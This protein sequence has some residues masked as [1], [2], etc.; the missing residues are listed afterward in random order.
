MITDTC[1]FCQFI[2]RNITV[3][4]CSIK[5][6][7]YHKLTSDY[8]LIDIYPLDNSLEKVYTYINILCSKENTM[9]EFCLDC[10]NKMNTCDDSKTKY[11]LSGHLDLCEGCGKQKHIIIMERKTYYTLKLK[12]LILP[13][14]IAYIIIR[15][16]WRLLI[17]PYLIFMYIKSKKQAEPSPLSQPNQVRT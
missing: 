14:I 4:Q 16:L 1:A 8:I 9:A 7:S 10:W 13:I 3:F 17:L 15:F 2:S 12:H 11:V 5:R 6:D